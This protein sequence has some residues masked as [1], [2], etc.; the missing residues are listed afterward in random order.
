[1]LIEAGILSDQNLRHALAEQRRWGGTIGRT[2]IEMRLV[3][4]ADLLTVLSRQFGV[5]VVDLDRV[6]ISQ[7]VLELVPGDLAQ[8]LSVVPFA[9]PMKFLDVAM[10]DPT[11]LGVIDEL[12]IRTQ[13]NIR[14]HLAGPK[15]LERAISKY[16]QRGFAMTHH[17]ASSGSIEV[18]VLDL[19]PDGRPADLISEHARPQPGQRPPATTS[20]GIEIDALQT[21]MSMLEALVARDE[22]VLRKLLSLLVS[23]GV[24]SREEILEAIR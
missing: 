17:G 13:L 14:P 6:T 24:A 3:R 5:P 1:M 19:H 4:E 20:R 16:Y 15:N 2:L 12:R 22:E 11:N 7:A 9:Q 10:A 18:D 8:E 23:K 21:R